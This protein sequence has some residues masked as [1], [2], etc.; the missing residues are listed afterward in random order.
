MKND[1]KH[2]TQETKALL[3]ILALGNQQIR[4]GKVVP[5]DDAFRRVRA[6]RKMHPIKF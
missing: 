1:K 6:N 3:T 2:Q 4:A 5:A